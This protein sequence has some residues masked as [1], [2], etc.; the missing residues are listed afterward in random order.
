M[1]TATGGYLFASK[2]D[3]SFA[4]LLA[5]MAGLASIIASGCVFNN[6]IDRGI[7]SKMKRTK[8]RALVTGEVSTTNALVFT[9]ILLAIGSFLLGYFTTP[10]AL[11]VAIFG[12]FA[13]VVVYGIWKRQ[14]VHGTEVGSISGAVPP[15]VGYVAVTGSLDTS[16]VI[17]FLLLVL[18]QMPHFYAIGIFR[19]SEIQGQT[20]QFYPS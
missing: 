15:V 5:M 7:D 1:I 8:N 16:A 9:S 10:L 6:Y 18:W 2:G 12:F 14:S 13:Y 20:S 4:T 3:I 19:R 11:W 17:L